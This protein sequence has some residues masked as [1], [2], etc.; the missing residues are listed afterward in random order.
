MLL[1]SAKESFK[2]K[3]PE[4]GETD[5]NEKF[6]IPFE[7][8]TKFAFGKNAPP[9]YAE[10]YREPTSRTFFQSVQQARQTASDHCRLL[11]KV[12]TYTLCSVSMIVILAVLM[13]IPTL[14]IIVGVS[15]MGKCPIE[16]LIPIWLIVSGGL[17]VIKNLSTLVQRIKALN[18]KSEKK[19][20]VFW[21]VFDT[22]IAFF[23]FGWFIVGNFWVYQNYNAMISQPNTKLTCDYTS[24]YLSFWVITGVYILV[25]FSCLLFCCTICFTIFISPNKK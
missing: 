8:T 17:S 14:M 18:I 10:I 3:D 21:N 23:L 7:A 15:T 2:L 24:F 6:R 1:N 4:K 22:L 19:G 5:L 13:A 16:P 25:A 12:G 20:N 9:S 11:K